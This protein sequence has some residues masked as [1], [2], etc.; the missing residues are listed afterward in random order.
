M[1]AIWRPMKTREEEEE[2]LPVDRMTLLRRTERPEKEEEEEEL[3]SSCWKVITEGRGRV[4][5]PVSVS[6]PTAPP[7][8]SPWTH[9]A[10]G[11]HTCF[12]SAKLVFAGLPR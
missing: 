9:P 2:F 12:W 3:S 8:S 5:L 11:I 10:S 6:I 7:F 4:S 1:E